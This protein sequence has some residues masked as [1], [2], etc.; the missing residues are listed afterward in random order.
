MRLT[1]AVVAAEREWVRER[2]PV[3]VALINETRAQL[4][5]RFGTDVATVDADQYRRAVDEVFADGDRAV[6][7]AALVGLLRD[8]DVEGDYPGFVVDE[9]LGRELAGTIAGTQPLRLLGEATFH[10]ADV[11]I[12]DEAGPAGVADGDPAGLD[13]LDAAL[14]AGFQTRLPGWE[15]RESESPFAVTD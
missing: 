14:A 11:A 9:L 5:E 1:P 7:V 15:W 2:A 10:Y 13:D 12:E 3:V 4:G 8:L 6:N